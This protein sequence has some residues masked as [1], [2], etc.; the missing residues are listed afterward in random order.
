MTDKKYFNIKVSEFK[1]TIGNNQTAHLKL[2][3]NN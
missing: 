1:T 3:T 2:S